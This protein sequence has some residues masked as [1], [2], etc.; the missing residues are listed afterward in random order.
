[1]SQRQ[2][3]LAELVERSAFISSFFKGFRFFLGICQPKSGP[4]SVL[5]VT[6]GK[7]GEIATWGVSDGACQ[8]SAIK[9]TPLEL[10]GDQLA[11]FQRLQVE[12]GCTTIETFRYDQESHHASEQKALIAL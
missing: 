3:S 12:Y 7:K 10:P 2:K 8:N 1:M 6:K 11:R 4:C 9:T 5:A